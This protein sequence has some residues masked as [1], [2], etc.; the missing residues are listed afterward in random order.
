MSLLCSSG[1]ATQRIDASLCSIC[2]HSARYDSVPH[3]FFAILAFVDFSLFHKL[4]PKDI[5]L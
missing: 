1:G 4:A 3:A 5:A 2:L